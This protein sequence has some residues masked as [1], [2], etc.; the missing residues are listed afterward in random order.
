ME[1]KNIDKFTK[2]ILQE[3]D[4]PQ[5]SVDFTD[6]IMNKI[7]VEKHSIV[8]ISSINTKHFISLFLLVFVPI[9]FFALITNGETVKIPDYFMFI[10]KLPEININF[11]IFE[12]IFKEN[13]FIK[14]LPVSIL[15]VIVIDLYYLKSK[16]YPV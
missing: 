9:I 12:K 1:N 2:K 13:T 11:N 3:F 16:R 14:T 8:K 15:I 10:E 6:K 4:L 7:A 5:V